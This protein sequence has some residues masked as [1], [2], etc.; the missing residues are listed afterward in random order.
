MKPECIP[1]DVGSRVSP[2]AFSAVRYSMRA[3]ERGAL[4]LHVDLVLDDASEASL[5]FGGPVG[6]R[7]LDERDLIEFWNSYSR[8]NGWL[9]EVLGGG[10]LELESSREGFVDRELIP[11]LREFLVVGDMCVSVLCTRPPV[12]AARGI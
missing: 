4:D 7:V 6:F 9:W 10:W 2:R 1:V 12:L 5:V 8:P 3:S 11:N